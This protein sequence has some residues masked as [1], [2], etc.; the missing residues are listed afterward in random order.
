MRIVTIATVLAAV[1]IATA[2]AASQVQSHQVRAEPRCQDNQRPLRCSTTPTATTAP[3]PTATAT[4]TAT[5]AP[6]SIPGMKDIAVTMADTFDP[7]EA[8]L[9][10]VYQVTGRN[11]G[12]TAGDSTITFT[13]GQGWNQLSFS[14]S[15]SIGGNQCNV[16]GTPGGGSECTNQNL[17]PGSWM[18]M[19]ITGTYSASVSTEVTATAVRSGDPDGNPSNDV[20]VETT[21]VFA[22]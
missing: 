3:T 12:D 22:P 18:V 9:P 4:A 15:S 11:I 14:S 19:T 20:A 17:A 1:G 7:I 8:G 5:P 21:S 2:F 6:T 10:V 13:P 16:G